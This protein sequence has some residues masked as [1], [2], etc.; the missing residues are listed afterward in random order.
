VCVMDWFIF[1]WF[2]ACAGDI[3]TACAMIMGPR[4]VGVVSGLFLVGF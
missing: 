2:G 3:K 1:G 4:G